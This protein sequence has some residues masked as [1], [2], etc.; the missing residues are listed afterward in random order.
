M[1]QLVKQ[2]LLAVVLVAASGC[3]NLQK[4][5]RFAKVSAAT[6]DSD[7]MI[8]DYV[9]SLERQRRLQRE[10]ARGELDLPPVVWVDSYLHGFFARPVPPETLDLVRLMML[11][12]RAAGARPMLAASTGR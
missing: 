2:W 7:A 10:D 8:A 12:V 6:A 3:V 5:S 11:E 4:V 1:P 9:G